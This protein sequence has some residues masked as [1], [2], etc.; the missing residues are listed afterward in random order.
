MASFNN[1][2]KKEGTIGENGDAKSDMSKELKKYRLSVIYGPK[3]LENS[4]RKSQLMRSSTQRGNS[5]QL[6]STIESRKVIEEQPHEEITEKEKKESS[7]KGF[8]RKSSKSKTRAMDRYKEVKWI[9]FPD[10]LFKKFWNIVIGFSI[11]YAMAVTPLNAAFPESF[12]DKWNYPEYSVDSFFIIDVIFNLFFFAYYDKDEELIVERNK[13]LKH[14][15]GSW[16]FLDVSAAIPLNWIDGSSEVVYNYSR[17]MKLPRLYRIFRLTRL[18]KIIKEK[19]G[20]SSM[21]EFLKIPP[22]FDRLLSSLFVNLVIFHVI[23]CLWIILAVLDEENTDNW[24]FRLGYYD[25]TPVSKYIISYYWTVQ[26]VFTVGKPGFE[27]L[28]KGFH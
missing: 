25:E 4:Q 7:S 19:K 18:L 11:F 12:G 27:E 28:V 3:A 10:D 6:P 22:G 20:M 17:Y 5:L 15:L 9:I 8:F 2:T 13:I 23:S 21:A 14:Y 16:F 1:E 26:T 24:I